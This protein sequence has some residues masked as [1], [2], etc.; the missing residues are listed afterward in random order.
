MESGWESGWEA[1]WEAGGEAVSGADEEGDPLESFGADGVGTSFPGV[2]EGADPP[3][4]RASWLD[5]SGTSVLSVTPFAPE[6]FSERLKR[7]A[8]IAEKKDIKTQDVY[9]TSE[10]LQQFEQEVATLLGKSESINDNHHNIF[11]D[12]RPV[13]DH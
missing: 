3:S 1:G 6:A 13:G 8:E 11:N 5:A 12:R 2:L 4:G 9:G 10:A 7:L